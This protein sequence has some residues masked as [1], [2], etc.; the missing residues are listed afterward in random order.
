MSKCKNVNE[1]KSVQENY[2]NYAVPS[3]GFES[4]RREEELLAQKENANL[5]SIRHLTHLHTARG[6]NARGPTKLSS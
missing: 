5:R 3:F 1:V 4:Q 2:T 6:T